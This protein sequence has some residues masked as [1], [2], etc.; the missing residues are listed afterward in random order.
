M[1][2]LKKQDPKRRVRNCERY[3]QVIELFEQYNILTVKDLKRHNIVRSNEVMG[4]FRDYG[5]IEI[6]HNE[7]IAN[8]M[9][10]VPLNY[11][12]IMDTSLLDDLK[13]ELVAELDSSK[14]KIK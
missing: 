5:F 9:Y 7:I 4:L 14:D 11:W 10:P 8:G 6:S 3:I 2:K 13:C 12:Q 1:R